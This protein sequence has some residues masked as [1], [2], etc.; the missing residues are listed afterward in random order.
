[1]VRHHSSSN[2]VQSKQNS[3]GIINSSPGFAKCA[4]ILLAKTICGATDIQT[5][6][7][8]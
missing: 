1:M 5:L 4:Q 2:D 3:T 6:S 8:R 7:L